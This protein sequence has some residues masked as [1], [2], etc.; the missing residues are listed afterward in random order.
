MLSGM[1]VS[2]TEASL[3][4][5]LV[6]DEAPIRE[7][8]SALFESQG[9]DV[10]AVGDGLAALEK[11]AAGRFDMVILDIMLPGLDG[12]SV[13]THL[14]A[15]GDITPVLLLTAKGA[16]DDIVRGLEKGADDYVTKPFGIHELV[17]R[18]KGL[19]RR[20][21]RKQGEPRQVIRVQGGVI[22]VD[23]LCVKGEQGG[24]V[25]LT[26]RETSLL[27]FLASR[28]HRPVERSELLVEVWGY[29]DGSI[30]TRTVDVHI[31]QLRA[32]LKDV[33]GPEEWIGTVRGRGY[34]FF[35]AL[36]E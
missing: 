33:P 31:Q 2:A 13:L 35:G 27:A 36:I 18:V 25:K 29:R 11:L 17:A 9:F 1:T 6:E 5:L 10:D 20:H 28:A 8:L 3:R 7:G 21:H 19:L 30:Q 14:R 23:E 15:R 16:E 26:A 32:K 22:D 12:L 34:R 4:V 24:V